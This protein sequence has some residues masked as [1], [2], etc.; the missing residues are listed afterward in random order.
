ML[1]RVMIHA[2]LLIDWQV[3]FDVQDIWGGARNNPDAE[4]KALRLLVAWRDVGQPIFHI[5][6]DRSSPKS[7]LRLDKPGGAFRPG[8]TPQ[9]GE[10]EIVKDVVNSSFIGTML[11]A[12]LRRLGVTHLTVAGLTTNHC[13]STTVRMAGNFGFEVNLVDEACATFDRTSADGTVYPAQLV[14]ELSL[15]NIDREFC[16]VVSVE[17]ALKTI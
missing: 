4:M 13:V 6:H 3:G 8:F 9:S 11:E 12:D 15:A 16:N 7:V 5:R 14:H 17:T 1:A 10:S 2:L